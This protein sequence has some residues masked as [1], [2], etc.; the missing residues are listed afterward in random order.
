[1]AHRAVGRY[2]QSQLWLVESCR[3]SR[4]IREMDWWIMLKHDL[5]LWQLQHVGPKVFVTCMYDGYP[6]P[7]RRV[8]PFLICIAEKTYNFPPTIIFANNFPQKVRKPKM[9]QI[10]T[11]K[12]LV[13]NSLFLTHNEIMNNYLY[14]LFVRHILLL[15]ANWDVQMQNKS[16]CFLVKFITWNWVYLVRWT[17]C[18]SLGW[19]NTC[20]FQTWI[21]SSFRL[22][23]ALWVHWF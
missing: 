9:R 22:D 6:L 17:P 5:S 23:H 12:A 2:L 14:A 4:D 1:M 20:C 15:R 16:V 13:F 8:L 10:A 7:I 3:K 21:S 11:K 19:Q 18:S